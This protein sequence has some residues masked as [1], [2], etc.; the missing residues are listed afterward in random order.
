MREGMAW[1]NRLPGPAHNCPISGGSMYKIV[2]LNLPFASLPFP[3]IA[4][5]QLK[6]VLDEKL[7]DRVSTEIQYL[8]HDFAHYLGLGLY[9]ELIAS[10]EHLRSGLGDWLFRQI[11]FPALPDNT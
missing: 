5:T 8:N 9:Q 4:L 3:S 11:V 10:D 6:S 7:G 1:C 2:L